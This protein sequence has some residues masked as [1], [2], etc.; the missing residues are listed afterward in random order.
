M[1]SI[2]VVAREEAQIRAAQMMRLGADENI[3]WKPF[4]MWSSW[5]HIASAGQRMKPE[6][7]AQGLPQGLKALVSWRT[8]FSPQRFRENYNI[9]HR[10][11]SIAYRTELRSGTDLVGVLTPE[12]EA[13]SEDGVWTFDNAGSHWGSVPPVTIRD[14]GAGT[15][16]GKTIGTFSGNRID[17]VTGRTFRW[18]SS[19]RNDH[20]WKDVEEHVIVS[21]RG[22]LIRLSSSAGQFTE[23]PLL[24]L[25][26]QHLIQHTVS[27]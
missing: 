20:A 27:D 23:L 6:Y 19:W 7:K 1:K 13:R 15:S 8:W 10:A 26:G 9:A 5:R 2:C 12:G 22:S 18:R 17:F 16:E 4:S 21:Y 14:P 11:M 24:V 3:E 25:L